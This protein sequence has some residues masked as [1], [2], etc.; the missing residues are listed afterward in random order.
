MYSGWARHHKMSLPVLIM[1]PTYSVTWLD[2]PKLYL[3]HLRSLKMCACN[4]YVE[5]HFATVNL[6]TASAEGTRQ[7]VGFPELHPGDNYIFS[8]I[9]TKVSNVSP[10]DGGGMIGSIISCI[11]HSILL[12]EMQKN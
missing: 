10:P 11:L 6:N 2:K 5:G 9:F 8:V 12:H 1:P 3:V 4:N 7:P